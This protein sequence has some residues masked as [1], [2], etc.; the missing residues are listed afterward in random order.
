M[1][2]N[3]KGHKLLGALLFATCL[4]I[5]TDSIAEKHWNSNEKVFYFLSPIHAYCDKVS[6]LSIIETHLLNRK[7]CGKLA[8]VRA[9]IA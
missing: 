7:P 4:L 2:I 5:S 6:D 8:N 3:R 1:H 9:R